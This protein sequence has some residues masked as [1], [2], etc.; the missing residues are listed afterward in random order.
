[1]KRYRALD[2]VR[3]PMGR[4]G[5]ITETIKQGSEASITFLLNDKKTGEK[6]AWWDVGELEIIDD[7]PR[8]LAE[9]MQHPF[10]SRK[11]N[12]Y[13]IVQNKPEQ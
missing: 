3:T 7:I 1:M 12:P 13:E 8:L 11:E 10:N 2:I 9:S 4:I 5:M 6:N